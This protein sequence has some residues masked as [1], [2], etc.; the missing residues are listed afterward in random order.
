MTPVRP[1]LTQLHDRLGALTRRALDVEVVAAIHE[2]TPYALVDDLWREVGELALDFCSLLL[3]LESQLCPSAGGTD[4][5]G[6]T[7]L[8]AEKDLRDRL[9]ELR[10]VSGG[11]REEVVDVCRSTRDGLVQLGL[12]LEDEL[13]T[14]LGR[15][16]P[17]VATRRWVRW[18]QRHREGARTEL[19][20]RLEAALDHGGTLVAIARVAGAHLGRAAQELTP[21]VLHVDEREE[22]LR[23]HARCLQLQ[24]V[25][26][27][28]R[29]GT[30]APAL[31]HD[32]ASFAAVLLHETHD[33]WAYGSYGAA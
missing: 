26:R 28:L 20:H 22:L 3:S 19:A 8:V 13:G 15:P 5:V 10:S 12:A 29:T 24:G 9:A 32:L 2:A 23:L 21:E 25:G 4:R 6:S 18:S 11:W 31:V 14:A 1:S 27:P 33:S 17:L 30:A 16:S 7:L